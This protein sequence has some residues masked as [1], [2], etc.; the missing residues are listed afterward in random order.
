MAG[1][2]NQQRIVLI[3]T[4][5]FSRYWLRLQQLLH[6]SG[7]H[8]PPLTSSLTMSSFCMLTACSQLTWLWEPVGEAACPQAHWHSIAVKVVR[9][10]PACNSN[11]THG[12]FQEVALQLRHGMQAL[13]DSHKDVS[14]NI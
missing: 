2:E 6:A 9:F 1:S 12:S 14:V 10:G 8:I 7:L 3:A 13:R 4:D 11:K 5:R